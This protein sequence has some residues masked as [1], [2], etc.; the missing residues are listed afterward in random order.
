MMKKG[1]TIFLLTQYLSTDHYF[2]QTLNFTI[3][4]YL[5]NFYIFSLLSVFAPE[6]LWDLWDR[7]YLVP[8]E[9]P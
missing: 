2:K 4:E 1:K 8:H 6:Y 9:H 7:I 5:V 3:F